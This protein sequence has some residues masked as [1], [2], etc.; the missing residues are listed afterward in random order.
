[1]KKPTKRELSDA[2]KL[3]RQGHSAAGRVMAE[4]ARRQTKSK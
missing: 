3:L 2:A 4:A 1:M